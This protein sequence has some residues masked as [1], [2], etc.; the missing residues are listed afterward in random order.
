[1]YTNPAMIAPT[2]GATQKSQSWPIAQSPTKIAW[3]VL[4]AGFT[5]VLVTG[6]LIKWIS[7]S[8]SPIER[9]AKYL[10][11]FECV[12]PSI[13]IR[14]INVI[15]ISQMRAAAMLYPPG[16]C[17]PKPFAAKPPSSNP[18]LPLAMA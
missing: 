13:I 9:P 14:N 6:I 18:A 3:L 5:D 1:M 16:E 17:S 15:A 7:V 10:G 2:I 11:A 4:R 12:D 8:P